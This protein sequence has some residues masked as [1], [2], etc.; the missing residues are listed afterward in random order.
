[1]IK[2][3][4]LLVIFIGFYSKSEIYAQQGKIDRTFNTLDDGSIG[5]GFDNT[6]RTL[7]IQSD[8]K[9]IVG[10]DY[11]NLNGIPSS[12]LTRLNTDGSIDESFSART[13]LN[14][15][16]YCSY[17]QPDGKIIVGGSFTAFNGTAAGRLIRLNTDGSQDTSFNTSI[18]TLTGIIYKI[19]PQADGKI[20]I[21]GSFT[22]YNNVT[23]NRVARIL[24][25]GT[26]DT[27]FNTGSG[28]AL[29]IT[30]VEVLSDGKI[31]LAGN[32]VSFNGVSANRIV[33]LFADGGVDTSFNMGTA[34]NDDVSA[35]ALQPDGKIILGGKFTSYNGSPANRIIRLNQD[36]TPDADFSSGAGLSKEAVQIIKMDAFGN[37]MVGGSF[38]GTYDNSTINRVFLLNSNGVLKDD[39]DMGSGPG[40]ASVLALECST[41]GSWFI[42]GSFSVFDSMNQGR[43]AKINPDGE[44]NTEYLSAGIGFDNSVL[45]VLSLENKQTMVFGNFNRFNGIFRSKIAR[46]LEN[47][48]LDDTFNSGQLGANYLIKSA[49][50]QTDGKIVFGGNFTKYNVSTCNRI[51][52]IL[53]DGEVD[54]TFNIGTGFNSQIYSIAIQPD[55][56][57]IVGGNFTSYNG[58]PAT[59]II[60]LLPDGSRDSSFNP[61]VGANAIIDVVLVQPDG[62]ILVG[63][64]F[65]S[66]DNNLFSGLVRLNADGSIDSVFNTGTGFDKNVYAIALQSD[67]RIIIGGSFLSYNGVAQKRIL[68]LNTNGSLDTTFESDSGFSKGDVQSII[69]Q[70]DDKILAGGSFSGTYKTKI[71]LRLIR[72]LK[73]GDYDPSFEANLNGKLY[74]MSFTADQKLMI[75][76]SFNSVSGNSKHRIARLKLCLESTVWN[77]VAWSNGLPSRGK[78]V[79]FKAD[80]PNFTSASI[81]HCT[82]D[83]GKT[84]TL[85]EGNS[86]NIEFDYNGSG[87]LVLNDTASLFQDDDEIVN[88]GIVHLKRKSSPI[89]RYDYTYWSSPVKNQKLIDVSPNT[90]ADKFLSFNYTAGYWSSEMASDN[91][92]SGKGYII[93]GPQDFSIT[94]PAKFEAIFKGIPTNGIIN[95]G[96]G[97]ARTFNLIGNP[98]P[99]AIDADLLILKNS[100][101][102]YGTLYFWTHNTPFKN[103]IYASDDYAVYNLLGG[104]GTRSS[105]SSGLNEI[106]PDGKIASG[107]AFFVMSKNA[108]M[109]EFNNSVRTEKDNST[110]FKPGK[111]NKNA[112]EPNIKKHRIWLNLENSKGVFKQILMGYIEGM[113][114]GLD[115]NA[116]TFNA[117]QFVDFYSILENKNLVIQGT[118]VPFSEKDSVL[119]GYQTSIDGDFSLKLSNQDGLFVNHDIYI[120]DR[121]LNKTHNLKENPYLF[122]TSKGTFNDRFVLR[123]EDKTLKN[124]NIEEVEKKVLITVKNK[125]IKII[126][127]KENIQDVDIYDISGKV[128]YTKSKINEAEYKISDLPSSDQVLIIKVTSNNYVYT[129][130]VV[131]Q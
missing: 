128:I 102:I 115:Y 62:K 103:N 68:R 41:D 93:R 20:I 111:E 82:I 69:V 30:N 124:K 2:K 27:T 90:S 5:D 11:L 50:L 39:F 48:T 119:L 60:R 3:I 97:N 127:T 51:A 58:S 125:S 61:G 109:V 129:Q 101:N 106:I 74:T 64:R 31:L 29:N 75:G 1:M 105:V 55:Q 66:F 100:E 32:F 53:P 36:G 18:G 59:R 33:R 4:L 24:S 49:A 78:E 104:V 121:V 95:L 73:S 81:C 28:S 13:G 85:L 70:P 22:K 122:S 54:A 84:V 71:A 23:V 98:Y 42:G 35:T 94:S 118:S 131:F 76:G 21:V 79:T 7:S 38:T 43:L 108:G 87:T 83:S 56:K 34:F 92:I 47:G 65:T 19:C 130:K 26:L 57:I 6:V 14:G 63:G 16:V 45:K 96:L 89:L 25:N 37:I 113:P 114:E 77:G 91:M 112:N 110:F 116:E 107:Q 99:S 80:Y 15:K 10:G 46:L 120:E 12:Y 67:Q 17:I 117:N 88:S 8:E 52:R 9:L 44:Y 86:L 40:S 72:L 126:S 123:Y